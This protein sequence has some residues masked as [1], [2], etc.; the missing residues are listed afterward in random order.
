MGK[1]PTL[2]SPANSVLLLRLL[3]YFVVFTACYFAIGLGFYNDGWS[4]VKVTGED[5]RTIISHQN[6]SHGP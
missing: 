5:G 4:V 6:Q 1:F 2:C 3:G